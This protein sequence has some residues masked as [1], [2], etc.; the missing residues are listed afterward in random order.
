MQYQLFLAVWLYML[1]NQTARFFQLIYKGFN[2]C[3]TDSRIDL[4][5]TY[6]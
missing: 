6:S 4:L 3:L 2:H 5:T 1:S